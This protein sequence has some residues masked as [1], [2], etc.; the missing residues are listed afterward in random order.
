MLPTPSESFCMGQGRHFEVLSSARRSFV[1]PASSM[2]W[3]TAKDS[4]TW[5]GA[6][7][8]EPS[9][10]AS[11]CRSR[12]QAAADLRASWGALPSHV[13]MSGNRN[14]PPSGTSQRSPA[15]P[16]SAAMAR[17][18]FAVNSTPQRRRYH[19]PLRSACSAMSW[20][21]EQVPPIKWEAAAMIRALT[22]SAAIAQPSRSPAKA[23]LLD[24]PSMTTQ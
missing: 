2:S 3:G 12:S 23:W 1:T 21:T 13:P 20:A 7:N 9:T 14:I 5:P 22:R 16:A 8:L 24:R 15:V 6:P 11:R 17:S 10:T 19:S 4:R 18:R